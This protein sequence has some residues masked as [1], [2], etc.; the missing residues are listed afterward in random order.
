MDPAMLARIQ[1]GFIACY[2]FLFVPMSIGTGLIMAIEQTRAYKSKAAEDIAAATFWAKV[3]TLLVGLGRLPS[4]RVVDHH[5]ELLD[6]D[7]GRLRR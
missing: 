4:V 7:P 5:R 6:A 2:H 1:F 3:F